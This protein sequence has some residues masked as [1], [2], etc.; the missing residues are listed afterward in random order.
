MPARV[1]RRLAAVCWLLAVQ[2]VAA[3]PNPYRTVVDWLDVEGF[4]PLGNVSAVYPRS[5]GGFWIAERCGGNDCAARP[6]L[7]PI[8]AV[9]ADGRY[10]ASFGA[11]AFVWPHGLLVDTAGNV[12]IADGRGARGKGFQVVKFA[13]DGRE[14]MRLGEAGVAGNGPTRFSGPTG[15]AVAADGSIFVTDGHE[16]D[17][18]HRVVKFAADGTYLL[19]WGGYGAAP[20]RFNVPHA[21]ALDSRGRVFIADRDNDRIQIFDQNG[22]FLEQWTQFGRPSGI[23]IDGNDVLYVSDNQSNDA[24]HP[25][26]RRGIRVGSARD[27]AVHAFIPDPE[28]DPARD[29]ETQAHGIAADARGNIYGAE[30]WGQTVKQYVRD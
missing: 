12:W 30:V 7:E 13:P 14:L 1:M 17:S 16:T 29:Q 19:E 6:D 3:Q 27:G 28:F 8:I 18:N 2:T 5:D 25:G 20:G 22:T 10:A 4:R 21:I 26:W 23:F 24:R 15:I 9:D 11:G